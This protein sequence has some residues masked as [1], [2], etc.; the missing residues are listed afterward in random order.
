MI[1]VDTNV[2]VHLYVRHALTGASEAL[3]RADSEWSA[4]LLWRS[5]MRNVLTSHCRIGALTLDAA[6][7]IQAEA[8]DLLAG[9]EYE[10]DS[11]AVMRLAVESGCSAY[12]CEFVALA[13][14]LG[15]KLV[16]LDAQLLA[17]FPETAV[18]LSPTRARGANEAPLAERPVGES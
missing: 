13:Q 18:A 10:I 8:E 7:A 9:H 15:V 4:P 16:T 6:L 3:Q 17:A 12:D 11:A 2:V 5:E 14:A 1:V